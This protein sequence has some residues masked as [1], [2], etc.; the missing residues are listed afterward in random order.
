MVS[1]RLACR[2]TPKHWTSKRRLLQSLALCSLAFGHEISSGTS[3]SRRPCKLP[4]SSPF[5]AKS[6][7]VQVMKGKKKIYIYIY[8]NTYEA[9]ISVIWG[10]R[11]FQEWRWDN[12]HMMALLCPYSKPEMC[13]NRS[14]LSQSK[15]QQIPRSSWCPQLASKQS[16]CVSQFLKM[17]RHCDGLLI[18]LCRRNFHYYCCYHYVRFCFGDCFSVSV[19]MYK[20]GTTARR[21]VRATY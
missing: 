18:L 2:T 19:C 4:I 9:A 12:W 5:W 17:R 14:S 10:L 16:C 13:W 1:A 11:M 15:S 21:A 7:R 3:G 8:K 20:W 6:R